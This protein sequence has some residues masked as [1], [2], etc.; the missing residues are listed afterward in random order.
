MDSGE[1]YRSIPDNATGGIFQTTSDGRGLMANPALARMPRY[2]SPEDLFKTVTNIREQIY[3][4]SPKRDELLYLINQH[5]FVR[6]FE[7]KF[8]R[9]DGSIIY[10]SL[11][12]QAVRDQDHNILCYEG[13]LEDISERK[14]IEELNIAKE[15]AEAAT[16]A[17]NKFLA[18]MS[19]ELR[20]PMNAIIGLSNLALN[21]DLSVKQRDYLNRI[22][23]SAWSLLGVINDILDLSNIAAGKPEMESV[24]FRLHDIMN[25]IH[26]MFCANAIEKGIELMISAAEDVPC[27][28]DLSGVRVLLVED[29]LINQQVAREILEGASLVVHT[30]N[31]GLEAVEAV[32]S[33]EYDAVIMDLEMPVMSGYEATRLIREESRHAELPIIAM[34]A[35]AIQGT[36]E[37]CLAAGMNDYIAKPIEK[38]QLFSVLTR[39]VKPRSTARDYNTAMEHEEVRAQALGSEFPESIPGIDISS[40]LERLGGEKELF[41]G[42][43]KDFSCDYAGMADEI[44]TALNCNDMDKAAQLAHAVRGVAGLLSAEEIY[45]AA[46]ELEKG[47][48]QK[49][50]D[51]L[52]GLWGEFDKALRQVVQSVK[53]ME[54]AGWFRAN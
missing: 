6:D 36:R 22:K 40:G 50:L 44:K 8:Y 9:K 47:I 54:L 4:E 46:F 1:K 7:M 2:D 23:T 15:A 5:G 16:K 28:A 45:R 48:R 37:A 52:E 24:D 38:G 34:T 53:N 42:L 12:V 31:N 21:T 27:A 29:N 26:G 20:K 30:A 10:V 14:H 3:V 35:H 41:A 11:N 18:Y 49:R 25:N 13:T 32:R 43:L 39:W 19:H 17:K 33:D 51:V